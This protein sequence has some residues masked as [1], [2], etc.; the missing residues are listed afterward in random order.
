M[1]SI[2]IW[3]EKEIG[4]T[5]SFFIHCTVEE[6]RGIKREV[7]TLCAYGK[8]CFLAQHSTLWCTQTRKG[9]LDYYRVL[10]PF[11]VTWQNLIWY[12]FSLLSY[13]NYFCHLLWEKFCYSTPVINVYILAFVKARREILTK[14]I[15]SAKYFK[16]QV[17]KIIAIAIWQNV[18]MLIFARVKKGA[19][20]EAWEKW[21]NE[22]KVFFFE[23]CAASW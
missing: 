19:L 13:A 20:K 14:G 16:L 15:Q 4:W 5:S 10:S 23:V 1:Y 21:E 3:L 18:A 11:F 22:K 12:F 6:C 9:H 2:V 17:A 7:S 8:T